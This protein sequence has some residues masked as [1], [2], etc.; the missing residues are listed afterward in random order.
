MKHKKEH[1]VIKSKLHVR[2]KHRE[3]YNFNE[4]TFSYPALAPFV[5]LN[6]HQ[7][8]SIDFSDPVA[9]KMLN[10]A[11][12]IHFYSINH[13]EIPTNYLCPPIPGRADYI[14]YIADL[15]RNNNFGRI[16]L[17]PFQFHFDNIVCIIHNFL[18]IS[19]SKY[20]DFITMCQFFP[21]LCGRSISFLQVLGKIYIYFFLLFS[22]KYI[23]FPNFVSEYI[24]M[25]L[26]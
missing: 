15:L 24:C 18:H 14:H 16:P 1:P 17:K 9:V 22:V 13:W 7:D 2:N 21:I 3:R 25:I 19:G 12:L 23:L 10:K 8:K 5:K 6:M 4:L 11:L 20:F 26:F